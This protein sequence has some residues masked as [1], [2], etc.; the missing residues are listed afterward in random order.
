M[1]EIAASVVAANGEGGFQQKMIQL[2]AVIQDLSAVKPSLEKEC[3][4]IRQNG[5]TG[6]LFATA[7]SIRWLDR[8]YDEGVQILKSF[9]ELST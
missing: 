7:K 6:Q 9:R 5:D 3:N 2:E 4:R 8:Q 1:K